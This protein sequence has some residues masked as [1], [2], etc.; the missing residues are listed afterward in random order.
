MTDLVTATRARQMLGGIGRTTMFTW[1][2]DLPDFPKA[3][4]IGGKKLFRVSD[5]EEF[6][7]KRAGA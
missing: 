6:V 3:I 5:L 2:R 4:R 1:E 7:A